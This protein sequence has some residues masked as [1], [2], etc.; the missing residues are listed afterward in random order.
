MGLTNGL[1]PIR[2]LTLMKTD[3]NLVT[4]W[5]APDGD[6]IG[7]HYELAWNIPTKDMIDV[8]AIIQ[9]WTDQGISADLYRKIIGDEVV[10]TKEM[11]SDYF[12]MVKMGLKSRYY[13]NSMTSAG[14]ELNS[15]EDTCKSGV[16]TL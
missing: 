4:H 10:G 13:Q 16:C 7:Q 15:Q 1:Y 5:S 11:L 3:G 8:Y 2:D 9:K 6:K 12:Y 14:I